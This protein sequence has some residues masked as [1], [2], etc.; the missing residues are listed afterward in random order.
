MDV[1]FLMP[2]QCYITDKPAI[3]E[4]VVGSCVSV[5]LYNYM[6]GDSAINH[7]L[8]D[9]CNSSGDNQSGNYGFSATE[10]IINTLLS[11]DIM[12]EHLEAQVF[13]GAMLV[14]DDQ[15]GSDIGRSNIAVARQVLNTHRIRIIRQ[16]VGGKRG[17]CIKFNTKTNEVA[18][19]FTDR[20]EDMSIGQ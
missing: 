2:G 19:T 16:E 11:K 12:T 9:V 13:G 1:V 8:Q 15:A 10:H 20:C 14:E 17:R 4:T 6:T 18:C 5:C 7:F 3:I